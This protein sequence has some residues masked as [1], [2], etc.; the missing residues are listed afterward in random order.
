MLNNA[1]NNDNAVAS[2]ADEMGFNP[3]YRRLCCG[4]YTLNL[5]GQTL[6]WGSNLDAYNNDEGDLQVR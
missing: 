6:L 4:P 3:T 2:I 5:V 1:L